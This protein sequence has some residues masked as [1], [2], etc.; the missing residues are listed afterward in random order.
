MAALSDQLLTTIIEYMGEILPLS[1]NAMIMP[2][3]PKL[4]FLESKGRLGLNSKD[5]RETYWYTT[6]KLRKKTDECVELRN[7]LME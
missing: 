7:R 5:P 6:I 3:L 1:F 4:A 2:T